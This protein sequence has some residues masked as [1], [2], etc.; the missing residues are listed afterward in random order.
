MPSTIRLISFIFNHLAFLTEISSEP[1]EH[2][3]LFHAMFFSLCPTTA[4]FPLG[5]CIR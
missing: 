1:A 2:P 4:P 5:A 3:F